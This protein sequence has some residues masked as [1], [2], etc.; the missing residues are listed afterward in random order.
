MVLYLDAVWMLNLLIDAC[1]LKLTAL[2]LRRKVS[3]LRLW[4]GAVLASTVVLI[5]F[6]PLS[7]LVA[8]PMGKLLFSVLIILTTF[9]FGRLSC[10]V[11]NLASFYFAAFA[12]GGGLFGIH[13]FF[14]NSSFYANGAL[15]STMNFGDPVSWIFVTAGFPLLW[16][17]SKKRFDQVV[18]R[19]WERSVVTGIQIRI[20]DRTILTD[21]LIDS[22]NKLYDPLTRVPVMFL[23]RSACQGMIPEPFFQPLQPERFQEIQEQLPA[24]W[25][26]KLSWIPYRS[27]DGIP[28]SLLAFRPDEVLVTHGGR[29]LSCKKVLVALTDQVLSPTGDFGAILHPDMLLHGK[30][31]D[32]AS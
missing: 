4:S 9:G 30:A 23:S 14:Q 15:L 24:E 7:F 17:F 29:L 1:L 13:Y 26:E 6:T 2:M 19:K 18:T 28:R 25:L 22:G 8:H 20:F 11:Q 21:A 32:R 3:R 5:L 12:V 27:V 31:I 16:L 10:F